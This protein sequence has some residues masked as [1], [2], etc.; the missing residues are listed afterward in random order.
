[1]PPYWRHAFD[2][3]DEVWAIS[4][5]LANV[6][7]Q[8]TNKP[9]TYIP[10]YVNIDKVDPFDR[11]DLNLAKK[12]FIFLTMLDFNSY[13][14]RN[15]SLGTI[16]AFKQAFPDTD[17]NERLVIKTING[18][19]HPEKLDEL[20]TFVN[21]DQRIVSMD[22]PLS[23]AGTCGLIRDADCFVSLH[24][25]EGFGRV[26]AEAMFLGTPV[27]ATDYSGSTTFLDKSNGFPVPYTLKDVRPGEYIFE[28]G[29][30]WAEPDFN[31]AVEAFQTV[32]KRKS[33]VTKRV[34]KAKETISKKHGRDAVAAKVA[35]RLA[36]IGDRL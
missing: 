11:E 16:A 5:F 27:I 15:N 12:D 7:T 1:M 23:R 9:V 19:V 34:A 18:H 35:E 4:H 29:S 26:I 28:E 13:I 24:R 32:R 10:P 22:G 33:I 30:Q 20:L 31:A 3:V 25:A 21:D 17:G 6:Y 8:H 36:Q 14:M 2:A